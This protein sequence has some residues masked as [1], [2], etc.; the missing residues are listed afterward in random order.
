MSDSEDTASSS[1]NSSCDDETDGRRH[2]NHQSDSDTRCQQ[3]RHCLEHCTE[4]CTFWQAA[5]TKRFLDKAR[6]DSLHTVTARQPVDAFRLLLDEGMF[7]HIKT[8]TVQYARQTEP[9]WD[10][11]DTE[12]DAFVGL[13]YLLGCMNARSFPVGLLWSEKYGCQ[14]FLS[15]YWT[16]QPST[17]G[18]FT[19]MWTGSRITRRE[20]TRQLSTEL[21][22]AAVSSVDLQQ[23]TADT[24]PTCDLDKR[25]NC[26]V[27]TVCRRNR[28][29]TVIESCKRPVCGKCM[30]KICSRL[31]EQCV[32]ALTMTSG[33]CDVVVC[34]CC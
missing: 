23:A 31:Q 26:Q 17:R 8:C 16:W 2:H 25:V 15:T 32:I 14:A 24:G 7:R 3:R 34:C 1:D 22:A 30:A 18:F 20:Y 13:L 21:T 10:M 29:V 9:S 4:N 19:R 6:A 27:K 11:T 28:T 5:G 12:L 33:Q